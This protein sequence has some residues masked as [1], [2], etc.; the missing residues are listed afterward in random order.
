MNREITEQEW[1]Q[2]ELRIN[3]F[4]GR[5]LQNDFSEAQY[6]QQRSTPSGPPKDHH[7]EEIVDAAL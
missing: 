6:D 7:D 4:T 1:Q 2:L 3:K 5:F